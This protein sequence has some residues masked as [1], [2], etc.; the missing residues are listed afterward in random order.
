MTKFDRN[1][2][3]Q[4]YPTKSDIFIGFQ[5]RGTGFRLD[6]SNLGQ[7]YLMYQ[8]YPASSWILEP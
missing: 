8:T 7:T 1:M 4:I 6:I 3:Y 2:L 5:N